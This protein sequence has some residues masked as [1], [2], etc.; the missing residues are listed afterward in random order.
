MSALPPDILQNGGVST[1]SAKENYKE[2][3][4]E[5]SD[6]LSRFTSFVTALS[7]HEVRG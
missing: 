2:E 4:I 7:G 1:S 5:A 6:L 3:V